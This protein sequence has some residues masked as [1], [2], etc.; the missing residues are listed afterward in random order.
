M[1]ESQALYPGHFRNLHG[2]IETAVSPSAPFLQFLGRVLSVMHQQVRSARQLHQQRIDP[3]AML[4]IRANVQH[5]PL[6]IDP[7]TIRSAGMAVPLTADY[8]FHIA[9]AGDALA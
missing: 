7:E 2:L 6:S 3:L 9:D 1:R 5:F 8:G 4:T